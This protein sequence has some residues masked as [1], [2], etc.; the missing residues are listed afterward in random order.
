MW[1]RE[2]DNFRNKREIPTDIALGPR[3]TS[4]VTGSS[5]RSLALVKY[6]SSG[7]VRWKRTY[8][9]KRYT[10]AKGQ[11]V[12]VDRWGNVYVAGFTHRPSDRHVLI[13]KYS[14]AGHRKWARIYRLDWANKPVA[15][16]VGNRGN[17][18]IAGTK[19]K[20]TGEREHVV[21]KYNRRGQRK[22]A[23]RIKKDQDRFF[24]YFFLEE[25]FLMKLDKAENIYITIP[26]KKNYTTIKYGRGGNRKWVRHFNGP[27]DG[28]DIPTDMQVDG[29]GNVYVTGMNDQII[30]N[31]PLPSF[32]VAT[33]K[34]D[35][36]GNRSWVS[37]Y[38][39]EPG[40]LT[41]AR[42]SALDKDGNIFVTALSINGEDYYDYDSS[43]PEM[44][45]IKYDAN[46]KKVWLRR[47]QKAWTGPDWG[48]T[49]ITRT[50]SKGSVIITGDCEDRE[51]WDTFLTTMKYS[52]SGKRRW[53]KV[54]RDFLGWAWYWDLAMTIDKKDGV[55]ITG[56]R[57]YG[58]KSVTLKYAP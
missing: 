23:R 37:Y 40:L 35:T 24:Y 4:Y 53:T 21:A 18:Y 41:M 26:K 27:A 20:K 16:E 44:V 36:D 25:P 31:S 43:N 56:I 39:N 17:F 8:K 33:V 6:D 51:T 45:I 49:F 50:D 48:G 52:A 2:F 42:S 30:G 1:V 14:P 46:G 13:V 9:P 58:S 34:Y 47:N 29:S 22:W 11:D 10:R 3:N 19:R 32:G 5:G 12:E 28:L 15:L 57:D 55:I 38:R 7:Q 54:E